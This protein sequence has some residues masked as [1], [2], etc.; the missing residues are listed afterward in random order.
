[1]SV[2]TL[3]AISLER[4]FAICKPLK[5]RRWQ[6]RCHACKM[7][8]VVWAA[9]LVWNTPILI[10]SRL[11]EISDSGKEKFYCVKCELYGIGNLP[12]RTYFTVILRHLLRRL[13][14][15]THPQAIISLPVIFVRVFPFLLPLFRRRG[16][17]RNSRF[18]MNFTFNG[19]RG[20]PFVVV[21]I[22]IYSVFFFPL[23]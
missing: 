7:I 18:L 3:V 19:L 13:Y 20:I 15:I 17:Y 14:H 11:K 12:L 9:S 1:M 5:S 6:T 2:W 16:H 4:Y 21:V 10:V 22:I 23:V 8:A